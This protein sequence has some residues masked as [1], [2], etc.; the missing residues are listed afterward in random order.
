MKKIILVYAGVAILVSALYFFTRTQTVNNQDTSLKSDFTAVTESTSSTEVSKVSEP[1]TTSSKQNTPS[2][3]QLKKPVASKPVSKPAPKTPEE[4]VVEQD[5]SASGILKYT[6]LERTSKGVLVLKSN[7]KLNQ[8][9]LARLNDMDSKQYFGHVSPDGSTV[10]TLAKEYEYAYS[11]LGENLIIGN[12]FDKSADFVEAWMN[13]PGHRANILN[14]DFKEIGIALSL[15]EF[16][17]KEQW[18]G[19]QVFGTLM[20]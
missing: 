14:G 20:S 12:T 5:I 2:E 16:N 10:S 18:I 8:I 13:S 9:A 19:V 17:G 1:S 7:Q 6:N 11:F 4:P 3:P 15:R